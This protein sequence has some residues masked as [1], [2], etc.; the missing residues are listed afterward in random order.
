MN[1]RQ[2]IYRQTKG[3]VSGEHYK[4]MMKTYDA[5]YGTLLPHTDARILDAGC[6]CG[7]FLYFLQHKGYIHAE[8]CDVSPEQVSLAVKAGVRNVHQQNI[9]DFIASRKEHYDLI[10]LFDVIEHLTKD[11]VLTHLDVVHDALRENGK[12]IISTA[13]AQTVF[14]GCIRYGDFTHEVCFTPSSLRQVLLAAHFKNVEIL[15]MN[16]PIISVRTLVRRIL[17]EGFQPFI[18]L[19]LLAQAGNILDKTGMDI[20][21]QSIIAVWVK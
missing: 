18:R 1:Y 3:N 12:V 21:T 11:E 8:G 4:A 6:G 20:L 15:P 7:R 2:R 13:N 16:T 5:I 9:L 10:T 17:W 14:D 19:L